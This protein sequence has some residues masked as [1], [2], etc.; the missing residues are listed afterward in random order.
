[1]TSIFS[2]QSG[3]PLTLSA[4]G[5]GAGTRPNL[6]PGIDPVIHGSRPTQQRV[7][8]WFNKAAFITPPAYTF[9]TVGRT[10]TTVRGPG[11]QN[12]DASLEKDTSFERV[13]V[14]LRAEFFNVTNTP[15]FS[16][17]DMAVQDAGFGTITSL[18]PSPPERQIQF[19]LKASF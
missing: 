17:P 4:A 10:F 11:V 16:M 13:N 9:G 14:E 7:N 19:A 6:V 1:M 8:A 2:E 5:V 15:H 3:F 12:V 18:I